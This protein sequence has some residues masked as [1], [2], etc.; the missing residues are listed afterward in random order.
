[1]ILNLFVLFYPIGGL[2][3]FRSYNLLNNKRLINWGPNAIY[4]GSIFWPVALLFILINVIKKYL[5]SK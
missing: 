1:M 5:A 2:I 3:L 4:W